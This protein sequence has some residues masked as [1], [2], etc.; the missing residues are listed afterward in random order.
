MTN[1]NVL[2]DL[3]AGHLDKARTRAERAIRAASVRAHAEI[4]EQRQDFPQLTKAEIDQLCKSAK[5]QAAQLSADSESQA[6]ALV[7]EL[8]GK[9]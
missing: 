6:A 5:A 8:G 3:I 1:K 9:A 7:A 2:A 4:A